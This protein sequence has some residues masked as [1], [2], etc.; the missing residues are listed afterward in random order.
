MVPVKEK[1]PGIFVIVDVLHRC[2]TEDPRD[3][4]LALWL[5]NIS[6]SAEAV[7]KAVGKEVCDWDF[8]VLKPCLMIYPTKSSWTPKLHLRKLRKENSASQVLGE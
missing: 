5:E 8:I 1:D 6:A 3:A 4:P 7:Y 2:L